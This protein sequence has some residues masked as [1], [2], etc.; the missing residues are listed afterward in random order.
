MA[1]CLQMSPQSHI[2]DETYI[3][4]HF[5]RDRKGG[6]YPLLAVM[7]FV[8]CAADREVAEPEGVR[9]PIVLNLTVKYVRDCLVDQ[10]LTP[11]GA[12]FYQY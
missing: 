12:S 9:P 2:D 1:H 8:R 3:P 11:P 10:D 6:Q 7:K 4:A 5:E